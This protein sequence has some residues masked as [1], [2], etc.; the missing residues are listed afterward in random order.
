MS[1]EYKK[2]STTYKLTEDVQLIQDEECDNNISLVN[3]GYEPCT[4]IL[5]H[6]GSTTQHIAEL[7]EIIKALEEWSSYE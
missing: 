4:G 6:W 3:F 1:K 2:L 5:K 7:R